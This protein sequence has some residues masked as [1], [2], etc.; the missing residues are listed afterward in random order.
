MQYFA[1]PYGTDGVGDTGFAG[2]D[3]RVLVMQITTAGDISG[4]M[5]VTV[6]PNGI[7]ANAQSNLATFDSSVTMFKPGRLRL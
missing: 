7:E 2:D 1:V 5:N 3:N 6:Y 4:Q